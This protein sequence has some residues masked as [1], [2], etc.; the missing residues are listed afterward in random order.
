[1]HPPDDKESIPS[2]VTK[3]KLSPHMARS[4]LTDG[5]ECEVGGQQPLNCNPGY[6]ES[7]DEFM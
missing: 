7:G 5:P 6:C 4:F 1:M 3:P 2:L